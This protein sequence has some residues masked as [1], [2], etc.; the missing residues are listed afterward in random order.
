M[1]GNSFC[2]D[3]SLLQHFCPRRAGNGWDNFLPLTG[4]AGINYFMRE[5]SFN[6]FLLETRGK[7]WVPN[8][9]PAQLRLLYVFGWKPF[10]P[11]QHQQYLYW[12]VNKHKNKA[13]TETLKERARNAKELPDRNY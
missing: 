3:V 4:F 7:L 1:Y 13:A 12:D 2:N 5:L 8:L 6:S 9:D 10:F 11:T